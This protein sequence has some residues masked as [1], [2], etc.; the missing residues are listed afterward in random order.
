MNGGENVGAVSS[1]ILIKAAYV[2]ARESYITAAAAASLFPA[3]E[4]C[5][6][7]SMASVEIL[8]ILF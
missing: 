7:G 4:E 1:S 5:F 6:I 2:E 3:R 8:P